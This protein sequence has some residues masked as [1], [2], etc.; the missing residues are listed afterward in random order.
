M[1][2]VI[3][4]CKETTWTPTL[5]T[6]R[7]CCVAVGCSVLQCVAVC[8]SVLQCVAVCCSVLQCVACCSVLQCVFEVKM[9]HVWR[10]NVDAMLQCVAV[11]CSVLQCVALFCSALQCGA[12]CTWDTV[13]TCV[14][15]QRRY[16]MSK[17][18]LSTPCR[19]RVTL[20]CS[21]LQCVAVCCSV[22]QWVAVCIRGK[23]TTCL[24]KQRV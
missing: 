9:Q 12:V 14:K 18:T 1:Q 24:K 15:K 16:N 4:M 8:C 19:H 2:I 3:N 7:W 21:V 10:H 5:E 11:C 17:E 13:T 6:Q 20:C 22:L 23:D